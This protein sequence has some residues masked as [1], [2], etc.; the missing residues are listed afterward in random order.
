MNITEIQ[1]KINIIRTDLFPNLEELI[2]ILE[3]WEAENVLEQSVQNCIECGYF[4]LAKVEEKPVKSVKSVV[5]NVD[6]PKV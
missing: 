2:A 6:S 4:D 1:N 5:E 3:Q